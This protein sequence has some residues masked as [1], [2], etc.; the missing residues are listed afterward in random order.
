MVIGEDRPSFS[1][2]VRG[3]KKRLVSDVVMRGLLLVGNRIG[4]EGNF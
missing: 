1:C 2:L 4:R 3:L